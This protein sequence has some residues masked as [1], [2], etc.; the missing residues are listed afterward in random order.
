MQFYFVFPF[1]MLLATRVG[2]TAFSVGMAILYVAARHSPLATQFV[3]PSPLYL[4]I[5]WF[6]IGML[7][8]SHFFDEDRR[9]HFALAGVV[10]SAVSASFVNVVLASVFALVV[11]AN[12]PQFRSVQRALSGRISRFLADASYSVYLVHLLI[13]TPIVWYLD[14]HAHLPTRMKFA[15]ATGVTLAISYGLAK[16]LEVVETYGH[17]LGRH[18][19]DSI[20]TPYKR[21]VST[22]VSKRVAVHTAP[23]CPRPRVLQSWFGLRKHG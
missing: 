4:S 21:E 23:A 2:W 6:T 3:Q 9:V 8:A 22:W 7:W 20:H 12:I 11:F 17:T 19:S 16:P 5:F 14:T 13:L 10:L 15:V 1:L 18:L